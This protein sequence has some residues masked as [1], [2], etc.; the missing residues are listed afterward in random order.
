LDIINEVRR[1]ETV[2]FNKAAVAFNDA[3]NAIDDAVDLTSTF[4]SGHSFVEI[5]KISGRLAQ[6]AIKLNQVAQYKGVMGALAQLTQ[7]AVD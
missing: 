6:H 4:Q 7:D 1:L 2:Q 3:I 5:A